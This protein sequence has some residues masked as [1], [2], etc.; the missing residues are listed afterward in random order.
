MPESDNS[1][2]VR[3]AKDVQYFNLE[4]LTRDLGQAYGDGK[5]TWT[6]NGSNIEVTVKTDDL[7][8]LKEHMKDLD[9]EFPWEKA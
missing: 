9:L 6:Q 3:F 8:G 7:V 4:T 1:G 5:A 2:I